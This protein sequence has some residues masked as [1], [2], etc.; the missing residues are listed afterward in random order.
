MTGEY[1]GGRDDERVRTFEALPPAH[2]KAFAG[3]WWGQAWL[4]ALEDSALD[5]QQVKAGRR[6]ARAGAVG[7]I[8]VRPGRITAVVED[9]DRTAHRSDVLVQPLSETGWDRL[10]DMAAGRAEHIA[11]LLE[12][13][14][15]PHLVAD[16]QAAGVDLLPGVGELEPA[17]DCGAWDHC[18]HTAALC[19]QVARLLD[20]DPFVLFLMRG[21]AEQDVLDALQERSAAGGHEES[22]GPSPVEPSGTGGVDAA[23]AYA[24]GSVLPPLPAPP[25]APAVAGAPPALGT[26][27]DPVP[28]IDVHGLQCVAARAAQ[29][30]HRLLTAAL[31][32]RYPAP[33]ELS[34]AQDAVRI[35]AALPA[36]DVGAGARIAARLA[37]GTGRDADAL[38]RAVRAWAQ[39]GPVALEVLEEELEPAPETYARARAVLDA[40]W[41]DDE[42]PHLDADR[43]RWT[44]DDGRAQVRLDLDGRW[45]PFR[46]EHDHWVPAGPAAPDP[47]AAL[48]QAVEGG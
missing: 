23:E 20:A 10:L 46:R 41:D 3:T 27:T 18:G 47:A 1:G 14:M 7:A 17:C 19:H 31:T 11:A 43:N 9:R 26:G 16:A 24:L 32:R 37:S 4:K 29:E 2:G 40:A 45:W 42:R 35:A 21:R 13:D 44:T 8:S 22:P 25:R 28:G 38:A 12:R 34:L 15:P 48:A 33:H 30:A 36:P 5:G 6:L 39:G